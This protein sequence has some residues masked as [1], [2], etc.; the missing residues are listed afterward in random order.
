MIQLHAQK[1]GVNVSNRYGEAKRA[2]AGAEGAA[3]A[4][5]R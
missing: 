2:A 3:I 1:N 4:H 5:Y